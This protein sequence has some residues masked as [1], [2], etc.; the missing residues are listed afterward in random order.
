MG[1]N[2]NH[3]FLDLPWTIEQQL[4][5]YAEAEGRTERHEILYWSW[6]QNRR[7]FAQILEYTVAS[8]PSYSQHNETHCRAV[9][10]NI[11]CLLGED[12]IRRL[13]PTDCFTILMAVYLHDVGMSMTDDDRRGI[14]NSKEFLE[15]VAQLEN[16]TDLD[17]KEAVQSLQRTDYSQDE[18]D[19]ST[20]N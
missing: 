19:D 14:V 9:I 5:A 17:Y 4:K 20:I 18:S 1:K 10:H 8:F 3:K 15:W 16:S 6:K 2:Q 13:S 7:W 12:E 11:E